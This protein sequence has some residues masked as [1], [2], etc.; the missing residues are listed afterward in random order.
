MV[1]LVEK[2]TP[3][4]LIILMGL[5]LTTNGNFFLSLLDSYIDLI[6]S[7]NLRESFVLFST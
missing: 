3:L 2:N 6:C 1:M 7:K 5:F 4:E